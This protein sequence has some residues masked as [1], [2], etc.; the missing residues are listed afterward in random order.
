[1]V[2]QT[3]AS[4]SV[5]RAGCPYPPHALPLVV[6]GA[7]SRELEMMHRADLISGMRYCS[8]GYLVICSQ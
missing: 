6:G 5:P 1:M 3:K 4:S 7:F 8:R 2:M